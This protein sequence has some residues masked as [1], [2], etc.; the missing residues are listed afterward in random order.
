MPSDLLNEIA[1]LK[2]QIQDFEAAIAA[3]ERPDQTAPSGSSLVDVLQQ[4]FSKLDNDA[5]REKS[6]RT[7]KTLLQ[8]VRN[9]LQA[10]EA[11]KKRI[12]DLLRTRRSGMDEKGRQ[13]AKLVYELQASLKA[14]RADELSVA[15]EWQEINGNVLMVEW[16]D[17]EIALPKIEGRPGGGYRVIL[18]AFKPLE[19]LENV[20]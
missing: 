9:K 4:R 18:E 19:E 15:A 14:L 1:D 17:A 8:E 13:I 11:H 10:R 16:P 2:S 3:L 5:E 7:A 12:G 6:L 20:G